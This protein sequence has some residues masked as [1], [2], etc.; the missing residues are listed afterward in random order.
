[1]NQPSSLGLIREEYGHLVGKEPGYRD[2]HYAQRHTYS[3]PSSAVDVHEQYLSHGFHVWCFMV[4]ENLSRCT[5]APL[6]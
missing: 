5:H 2:E 1:M 6:A 3:Q 4:E